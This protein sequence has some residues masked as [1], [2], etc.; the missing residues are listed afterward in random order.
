MSEALS[1]SFSQI[2][3]ARAAAL[4]AEDVAEAARVLGRYRAPAAADG[5]IQQPIIYEAAIAHGFF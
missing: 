1:F 3:Q 4:R 5:A 2:R